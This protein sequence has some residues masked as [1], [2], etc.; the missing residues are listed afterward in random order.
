MAK[1]D[2]VAWMADQGLTCYRTQIDDL[3]AQRDE[4]VAEVAAAGGISWFGDHRTQ[5]AAIDAEVAS[6]EQA[7]YDRYTD[8]A[9]D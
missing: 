4:I 2:V 8:W 5:L 6:I 7:A 1:F 9:T 3:K